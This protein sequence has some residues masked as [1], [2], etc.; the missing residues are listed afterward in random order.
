MD[1]K[2][3][4]FSDFLS[5]SRYMVQEEML[6]VSKGK[7]NLTIGIPRENAFLENR[8]ALVPDAVGLL[9]QNG[10]RVIIVTDAGKAA[11][12]PDAG[13][14]RLHCPRGVAYRIADRLQRHRQFARRLADASRRTARSRNQPCIRRHGGVQLR[15]IQ[16]GTT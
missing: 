16:H 5:S 11:H 7:R 12:F 4:C 13:A 3:N 10:H 8:I 14:R 15:H 6:E 9:V 2:Q 1:Q